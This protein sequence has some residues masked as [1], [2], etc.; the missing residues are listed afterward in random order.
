MSR[1]K[2][3]SNFPILLILVSLGCSFS[4]HAQQ[5]VTTISRGGGDTTKIINILHADRLGFSKKDTANIIQYG[6]GNVAAKQANTIFYSDSAVLNQKSKIFQAYGHVHINDADST[7]IYG[8]YM[9]YHFDTKLAYMQK[10]VTLTDGKSTLTTNELEY[11]LNTKI[12][13]YK[14]G[15]KVVNGSSVLT[16]KEGVY[17]DDLKD[18]FFRKDVVLIDPKYKLYADSLLYNTQSELATFVGPT[19]IIDSANREIVTSEGFYDIK[20]RIAQFGKRPRIKDG[21]TLLIADHIYADDAN[22]RR[23]AEGNAVYI[24]S[25]EGISMLANLL[26]DDRANNLVLA[27]KNPLMIIKQDADSI[28]V[29]ADTILSGFVGKTD[30]LNIIRPDTDTSRNAV[31]RADSA[32]LANTQTDT[33]KGTTVVNNAADSTSNRYMKAF[34]NVRIFSDS[35]QAV[36]D[37]LYYSGL[38]S[39]FRLFTD[40]VVWTGNSQITGDTI[41]L[42][43]KNKQPDRMYVFE[44]GLMVNKTGPNQYNQIKGNTIN[45][46]FVEGEIDYMRAKGSAESIYYIQDEDSAYVGVNRSTADIIDMRF[47]KRELN[48]VVFINDVQGTTSPFRQTNFSEMRLRN[49]KWLDDRRPKTKFELFASQ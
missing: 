31:A 40:P 11:D 16:S 36:S 41:Y 23:T 9:R 4:L 47:Q 35:L 19:R 37:S 34:H 39:V 38:D 14:N 28:Y 24:D 12:G 15:G 32:R 8:D 33:L 48:K 17:Y 1:C 43:T 22:G 25:V 20:N 30:S 26:V 45:G 6:A 7:H 21:K 42:F 18:V 2:S 3:V 46:Y 27:T 49:F 5:P 13:V 10:N 29:T 44:N